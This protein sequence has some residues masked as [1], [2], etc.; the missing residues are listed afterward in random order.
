MGRKH[1]TL[2]AEM[3]EPRRLFAAVP[4]PDHVVIAVEE[5]H[6]YTD[7][8]GNSDAAYINSLAQGGASMDD[9]HAITHPSQPNYLALFSGSTQGVTDD[10]GPY[11]F[12]TPNLGA[13]LIAT[14]KTFVG[15]SEDLPAVGSTVLTSGA[16]VRKHNP[17]SDFTNVPAAL[18]Q[19]FSAF[20]TDFT[21]LPTVSFVVPN[22]NDDM[23]D[24]SVAAGDQWLQANLGTYASWAKTHNSLFIVVFDEDSGQDTDN[25][26][27]AIFYGQA[28]QPGLYGGTTNHY[29]LLRTVEDMYGLPYAGAS[30]TASPITS[31]W[32]GSTT[33]TTTY[34][35]DLTWTSATVGYGTI[36]LDRSINGNT[37]TLRGTPYAKGIG[38]HAVS[39]IV[40]NLNGS[41]TE[42]LSDVGVDDEENGVGIGS[43]DFQVLGDG[44]TLY[45][46]G[47]LTNN[48]AVAHIDV[49]VTGVKTLT[50]V[51]NN[52]VAGINY[53]HADWAG[54]RLLQSPPAQTVPSA[55][56]N[57]AASIVSASEIDL[58]W[59]NTANNQTGFE[60]DRSTDGTH[61]SAAGVVGAGAS[62]FADTGLAAGQTYWYRVLATNSVGNS[63]PSNTVIATTLAANATQVYLS[64]LKWTSAT[65]GY[66]TIH[67]DQSING[68]PI[69]LR[70]TKYAKGIGTHAVS[71]I[72]YSLGGAYTTFK[73]DVGVDDEVSGQGS[74]IFQV[75][76]DGKTLYTSGALTGSSAV[77]HV[78][79]SVAGV[80]QLTLLATNGV[81]GIDYDHADWAGAVLLGTPAAPAAPSN[82]TA[83]A[84]SASQINLTWTN[85]AS[86]QTGIELDRSTDG[87]NFTVLTN[88]GAATTTYSDTGLAA[89]T[90]YSYRVLATNSTGS[91]PPSN[92][93][94]GTTFATTPV[95]TY[96][97]S[98][99]WTSATV[100]YGTIQKDASING[101]PITLNGTVYAK[102]IGTHANSTIVYNLAGQYTSFLSDVG[103]DDEERT[104]GTVEFQVMGDGAVLF[105]SG[106]LTNQSPIVHVNVNV[107]GVKTLT[108]VA[109]DGGDGIDYDHADWAGARLLGSSN[110]APSAPVLTSATAVSSSSITLGWTNTSASQTTL[111]LQRSTD[112]TNFSPVANPAPTA[113]AYTDTGLSASTKYY[114][115][116]IA[117]NANGSSP[118]SN[119]VSA[120]TLA[121][122]ATT[123]YLSALNWTSATVGYGTI[124]KNAS[125]KGNPITLR[126]TTYASGIGTHANSTI[127]YALNG[128]YTTFMSDVGIDDE[129]NGQGSVDFQV[130]GNGV[131]LYDSGT[132]TGSS[133]VGHVNVSVVG[134]QTLTLVVNTTTP[135]DIDYDHADWAAARLIS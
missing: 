34:L 89:N 53:D 31:V 3:L 100:G 98:L 40:Y 114:Y 52:G 29:S 28:V 64:D 72:V 99:T 77:A 109:S 82:L 112:G 6:G 41:Y 83:A 103:V 1:R 74:V 30:A 117:S 37:I 93:A 9:Y 5:N 22:L 124:Q 104:N 25:Q 44:K 71:Q 8:I 120:T 81:A 24:G 56:I 135:G 116:L 132:V 62:T 80:Q 127:T 76:G 23:H 119:V 50:L 57:L 75:I 115:R 87:T 69:T 65:V 126:G 36:Q 38:T 27:P 113:T 14:G 107:A 20:P 61:F 58:A 42:F 110:T 94:Q 85:N 125:I 54:A 18:N 15:Y 95:T 51:A 55:P 46:S 11:T 91:S 26:V 32:Q 17:W 122:N 134:V 43:V 63:A 86:N 68:N 47:V 121:A 39:Q 129:V 16:Y 105:D 21:K 45:D 33:T 70:G 4:T 66:G 90:T 128:Q 97:S 78:N 96:L 2:L 67:L 35:S 131:L 60:I 133:P 7:I 88:L 111:S 118:A 106:V 59:T 79:V 10:G 130:Y 12:S 101:N 49:N 92:V 123:T 102:G 48:S 108:L 84:T 73:S 19:P 13:E